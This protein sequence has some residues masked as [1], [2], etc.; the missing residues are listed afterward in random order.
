[1]GLDGY[2]TDVFSFSAVRPIPEWAVDASGHMV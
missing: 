1:M 2:C